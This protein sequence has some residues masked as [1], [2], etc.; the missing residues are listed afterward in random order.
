MYMIK[1][2]QG[3]YGMLNILKR[4]RGSKR[5]LI[6]VE[7][8]IWFLYMAVLGNRLLRGAGEWCVFVCYCVCVGCN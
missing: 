5:E 7:L 1:G 3:S 4:R 8:G 2:L 6:E